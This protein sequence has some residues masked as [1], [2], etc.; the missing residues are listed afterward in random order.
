MARKKKS[1]S[2]SHLDIARNEGNKIISFSVHAYSDRLGFVDSLFDY[3]SLRSLL[4]DF[5]VY[6]SMVD[7]RSF[8]SITPPLQLDMEQLLSEAQHRWLRPTEICEILQNYHKFHIASESPT[9]PASGSLFLFDRKVLRYFRKDGHNWRKKKDGKTIREAHEKLKVGSIDVL[10]CYYAHGEANE[11][12]QRRCYWMLEQYYYRK[13]SSHWVLVATLSLFSFGYLRPSWVRHLMHIVFVHY[14]EVKGNRTS[15]GMKENNSNSVNGTAS[16]NIDSTASPTST[17][18]SLCEDADTVLVQGIVNKQVPSYDHLLNLKLEIA[19]VGHLLLACVMFHR[20]MGT[21]S[22]KMQPSNTDSMLVEENS[23]KGGRLKAEHIRNP[24]QTQFNWQDDTDLALFEQSAQD[25]FETFSSLLGSENLQPFGIS[26][27][28]PPSNMDSE[29]MPVMKILRRSEDSLKKVDS[30]SKWAIKELGEMED[31]QM[32]SSRG[33]IAWTTVECETAAAGISLSPSLSEDQRFTIVDFWPKSAKTD[34]EVEVMVIGTFLL[35][36]QEVTKYNWSC[37]FG[38]VEVPAEILVDGVLCCHAPPHTAGH[39]PFYV[40]CSNRFACSEVREFDFLSGSTQ[41][42]N[43]TDVYGTYTNEASLQ[44][45]FEKMLAHRDFVHEHHIFEDV[46]DKRRQISKIMLLK[47]EKEYL[48]PGTYQRDS[49]KQEPKGQLFRELFEEELYIWL[50]HK[51]TEEGKG[52]NIL[53]EDGQGILHFVAALGYDWAIKPVLAAGVNI[54]FRDANGWSALHWAA[55]SGRE[56]T[57]AVLVSLGADAGALT[58]PSPELPLGKTAADLA[59]AN[60]HR[61]ISGFLAESSLTSYLEKLTVDSKENSPANSCGEKAVQTVSERTA[62]PM[63]YGDVPEKLSLKDS[64]TAV[65]N[66][67]QAADRLHQVF[68]MQ[69]FQRKQ[70]CDIGDDE[71]IDIS[72]QLAVSFAASKTK[73]PGQGD[74]SLSCAA[75]HIQKKY[76]GWKKRKEFLLIRQRIVKIQAHV[77]GH[78]VRKQYRTV[79]WSVGLLEKIILR[80]RRKGNGLRGFKRNAVAKT[81][82]PEP[83]VSAIC[84][85]IPQEDEYDYLKEGRKQTE[86]R[87]QKALTRVKSMVQYPEARDQYRRLLTVV[88]GFRENEASSSASINNK[89]EEAVNCEEDDFI[90][91]ESLLNDDTLMMSIS[92]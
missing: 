71:K 20:F 85:R 33:D 40:T 69:S 11:N 32:Q 44:L 10:H 4:V 5:W 53:D 26:Y 50:I 90:D 84:P 87:L 7:R 28:A 61:G 19:M 13:A 51:V 59:Y 80:W 12:F 56:E 31:L 36:P 62:A 88:E 78:Q 22:E 92:P 77:R 72:D 54:N 34:A 58:D 16:V 89:E 57:V 46:G 74:V 2:F 86:E 83:P 24:L 67:T 8:G 37:M 30:F 27:Q 45:R 14:L 47:E 17:L 48:L 3:E 49:T 63:T 65:R 82:E 39:V 66:A 55:F 21:E 35:S 73:N 76:R 52:P 68:R 9:R 6:P 38:E 43:A 25:N 18:S 60:G 42:I 1:V 91:I 29:Y 23:E 15:I 41:K 64:L 79:I 81:V 75:T 70:L